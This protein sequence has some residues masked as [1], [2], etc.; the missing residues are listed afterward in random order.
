MI[1]LIIGGA[2]SGKSR[3]ALEQAQAL[4]QS[5]NCG[6]T[7]VATATGLDDEMLARIQRHKEERPA[8]WKLAEVPLALSAFI[9]QV[10][11]QTQQ[12]L[13]IDCLTLWLNN[14]LFS[15][16]E[17]DFQAL[18]SELIHTLTAST[19]DIFIVSNEVGLGV[20]P[21]G[22]ISRTFVDQAGWL[23]QAMAA[24]ADQVTFIAAGLPMTLKAKSSKGD[25]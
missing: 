25:N 15:A 7:F 1:H 17:Q 24:A 5:K 8:H 22:E 21:M 13:L 2:R 16:P 10:N 23:N 3:Y 9:Q 19:C 12:V 4:S 11:Q 14:Q 20:I 18:F 6:V